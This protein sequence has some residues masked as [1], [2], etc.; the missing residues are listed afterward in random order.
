M[1]P[2]EGPDRRSQDNFKATMIAFM[3]R[4]DEHMENQKVNCAIHADRTEKVESRVEELET[5]CNTARGAIKTLGI[6]I[7]TIG[8]IAWC[9][10]MLFKDFGGI[11]KH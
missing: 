9:V 11:G 1:P 3:A 7:P 5:Y 10:Y 8:S 2:Y 6:G 4:I